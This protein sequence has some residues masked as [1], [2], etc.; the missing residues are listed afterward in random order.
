M[1][2]KFS[3]VNDQTLEEDCD[4]RVYIPVEK[5][6]LIMFPN[7]SQLSARIV[8]NIAKAITRIPY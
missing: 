2:V 3:E 8:V 6:K 1:G 4:E 7:A 5:H